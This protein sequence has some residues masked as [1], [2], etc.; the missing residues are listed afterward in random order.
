MVSAKKNF[1]G[2]SFIGS[3]VVYSGL[4]ME[5]MGFERCDIIQVDDPGYGLLVKDST[6]SNCFFEDCSAQG[7]VFQNVTL[8]DV[9]A[10]TVE[11]VHGCVFDRVVLR[12][13]IGPLMVSMPHLSLPRREDFVAG[14]F[15]SYQG[16][17][18]ALDISEAVF[19]DVDFCGV[20]GDLVR[21]D[22]NTQAVIRRDAV[23]DDL[24]ESAPVYA[25]IWMSRFENSPFDSLVCVAP[26]GSRGFSECMRSIEWLHDHG[27]AS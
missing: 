25:G 4:E 17:E 23:S 16:V 18:W 2:K 8:E 24:L 20:P 1:S 19:S 14:M 6:F 5:G 21:C 7:V 13:R 15:S 11:Y 9:S 3:G 26:R 12:G 10:R 27:V 22:E